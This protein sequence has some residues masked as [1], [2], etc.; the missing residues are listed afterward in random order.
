MDPNISKA[1]TGRERVVATCAQSQSTSR[2]PNR[3]H[4]LAVQ[5]VIR[6]KMQCDKKSLLVAVDTSKKLNL[7]VVGGYADN[8]VDLC[9]EDKA[10]AKRQ[11][12]SKGHYTD[13]TTEPR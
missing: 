3:T 10:D 2:V 7:M 1:T 8:V 5:S 6:V 13:E 11:F 4:F 12:L 9:G